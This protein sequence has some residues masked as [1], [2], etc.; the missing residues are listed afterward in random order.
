MVYNEVKKRLS[1][2][3]ILYYSYIGLDTDQII[4]KVSEYLDFIEEIKDSGT[5]SHHVMPRCCGYSTNSFCKPGEI[6][7]VNCGEGWW[8]W[9]HSD[10]NRVNL[11]ISNHRLAH[12]KLHELFPEHAG[13]TGGYLA[14]YMWDRIEDLTEEEIEERTRMFQENSKYMRT[15][16]SRA[17]A[18]ETLRERFGDSMSQLHTPDAIEKR[19][20]TMISKYGHANGNTTSPESKAKAL[21]TRRIKYADTNGLSPN[22]IRV[23]TERYGGLGKYMKGRIEITDGEHNKFISPD[24]EIPE[25][26]YRGGAKFIVINN[27]VTTTHL[28]LGE[29]IPQGWVR[30]RLDS[31]NR[32][33]IVI[34]DGVHRRHILPEEDIPEG[35]S[36]GGPPNVSAQGR[37]WI[38]DSNGHTKMLKSDEPIPEGWSIGRGGPVTR[39]AKGKIYIHKGLEVKMIY[40]DQ[41]IPEG[42]ELGRGSNFRKNKSHSTE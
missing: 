29:E 19:K 9:C 3:L 24:E 13:F 17:K 18:L 14:F 40:P 6:G 37:T 25:G 4:T 42:W 16:E 39:K 38:H 2:Y 31:P 22:Y 7:E 21:A 36:I 28:K 35:W 30:G 26:W 41:D 32:G 8:H 11:S 34:T 10:N 20:Q 33:R 27:G 23:M 5:E 1:D 12:Q 15:P